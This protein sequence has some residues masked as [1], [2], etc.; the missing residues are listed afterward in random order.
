MTKST[1]LL[2]LG[3]S[4]ATLILL[5]SRPMRI[6]VGL[7]VAVCLVIAAKNTFIYTK[8]CSQLGT[9]CRLQLQPVLAGTC[10]SSEGSAVLK[11]AGQY[12]L[13]T[14]GKTEAH[15]TCTDLRFWR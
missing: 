1:W 13:V 6:L 4:I 5:F 7:F 15:A 2:V 9:P 12:F 8:N 10:W 14:D 3:V 11:E